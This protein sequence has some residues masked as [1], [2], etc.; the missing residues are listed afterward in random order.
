MGWVF[1]RVPVAL[2][3]SVPCAGPVR[4]AMT[5][6]FLLPFCLLF[7]VASNEIRVVHTAMF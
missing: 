4:C 7:V 6:T 5:M 1:F 2:R 3:R